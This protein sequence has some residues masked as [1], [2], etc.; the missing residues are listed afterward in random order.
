VVVV[1][2]GRGLGGAPSG[3]TGVCLKGSNSAFLRSCK[4]SSIA[5]R[6]VYVGV[7]GDEGQV[8]WGV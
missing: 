1:S 2:R 4:S 6:S 5:K 7:G 3:G 8:S